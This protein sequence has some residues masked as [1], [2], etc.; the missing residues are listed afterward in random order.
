MRATVRRQL[1]PT[2][3]LLLAATVASACV[4]SGPGKVSGSHDDAPVINTAPRPR[5]RASPLV[6]IGY[7]SR[8]DRPVV[9]QAVAIL[10]DRGELAT[11]RGREIRRLGL[12]EIEQIGLIACDSS[13]PPS[14]DI[15]GTAQPD[16]ARNPLM[17]DCSVVLN[18]PRIRKSAGEWD[19]PLGGVT[20]L[21]LIHEQE[22]CI[23]VPDDRETPAVAAELRLAQK[24]RDSRLIAFVRASYKRLD[25]DGYWKD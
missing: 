3:L 11:Q 7:A 19:A 9:E 12:K 15:L 5:S 4:G 17:V 6:V 2:A 8:Q 14:D 13:C 24:L 1:L 18:M 21:V 22:H 23:R 25:A 16:V 20:A 10:R